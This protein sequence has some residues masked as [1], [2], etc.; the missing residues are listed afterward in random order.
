MNF[1]RREIE[2]IR[3]IL[4]RNQNEVPSNTLWLK[5]CE[6][7]DVGELGP[8]VIKLNSEHRDRLRRA[9]KRNYGFD[10]LHT[11]PSGD[12]IETVVM[13]KDEKLFSDSV[14]GGQLILAAPNGNTIATINGT[15]NTPKG[16]VIA[17]RENALDIKKIHTLV[18][19]ENG[20]LMIHWDRWANLPWLDKTLLIYRGHGK[21]VERV[22]SIVEKVRGNSKIIC[23][24][25][26]DPAGFDIALR[27]DPN[28]LI[29]PSEWPEWRA[30]NPF[31]KKFNKSDSYFAQVGNLGADW[32]QR[33]PI[34]SSNSSLGAL[35]THV[36]QEKLAIT[37]E[38]I[39]AN[40]KPLML[41]DCYDAPENSVKNLGN[42]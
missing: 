32:S 19:V 38:H 34:I 31:V 28:A 2:S 11:D 18:I 13:V 27:L 12:R 21:N 24:P 1:S 26:F 23:F 4:R 14:F 35:L 15:T 10:P 16:S 20:N 6:K 17:L 3:L 7:C 36:E 42:L 41:L 8:R 29:V 22:Q 37:Q 9:V 40:D 39:V 5:L 30:D 25:D 33:Y